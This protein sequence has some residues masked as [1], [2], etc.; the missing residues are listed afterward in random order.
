M[1]V[2]VDCSSN[3]FSSSGSSVTKRSGKGVF[4]IVCQTKKL[5]ERVYLWRALIRIFIIWRYAIHEN[6]WSYLCFTLKQ[7]VIPMFYIS[8]V[9]YINVL[10]ENS[11]SNLTVGA[12]VAVCARQSGKN[13]ELADQSFL[14][15]SFHK[16]K[17]VWRNSH[18]PCKYATWKK[19]KY[20]L[21]F[22]LTQVTF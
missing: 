4:T 14:V 2:K 6:I 17:L 7:S 3:C 9:I 16:K 21:F 1:L 19:T 13:R 10:Q 18:F 15:A 8:T 11:Q 12:A 5:I 22:S 20:K